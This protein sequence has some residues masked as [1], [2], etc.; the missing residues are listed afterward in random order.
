MGAGLVLAALLGPAPAAQAGSETTFKNNLLPGH[1]TIHRLHRETTRKAKRKGYT[2]KLVYTQTAEWTQCNLDEGAPNRMTV[3]QLM[4]DGPARVRSLKRGK[5]R[6]RP[7]PQADAFGLA[8]PSTRLTSE[9]K[10]PRDAPVQVPNCLPVEKAVLRLLL[11]VAHWPAKAIP[12]GHRWERPIDDAQFRGTQSFQFVDIERGREGSV[13]RLTLYVQGEFRRGLAEDWRFGKGQ[14]IVYWSR[15]DRTLLKMEAR[16]EFARIRPTGD[17]DY[18]LKLTVDAKEMTTLGDERVEQELK[19]LNVFA[20]AL[21]LQRAGDEGNARSVCARFLDAWPDSLWRPAVEELQAQST[22]RVAAAPVLTP[23]QINDLLGRGVIA[24]EAARDTLDYDLMDR[25]RDGLAA[26]IGEHRSRI[27]ALATGGDEAARA[28]AAFALAVGGNEGDFRLAQK[29]ARDNSPRV[30]AMALAGLAGRA[31]RDTSVELLMLVLADDAPQVRRRA[32]QAV[33]ACVPREHYA[34]AQLAERLIRVMIDDNDTLVRR[35]AIRALAA[36]G[37]P[38]DIP[39][40]EKALTHEL[41]K[42]NRREIEKAIKNL[43]ERS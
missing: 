2:E 7:A 11:D 24:W 37:A 6:V 35:H 38:A 12:P 27:H 19:Q 13:A 40:L 36:I 34:I 42:T 29:A 10:T 28:S 16:A 25:T 30:R 18:E 43:Q 5:D 20:E 26:L 31:S 22:R 8:Q 4:V 3:Y 32:C 14:A 17:E 33:A 1:L 39:A 9:I 41:D 15:M 21:Q 23:S